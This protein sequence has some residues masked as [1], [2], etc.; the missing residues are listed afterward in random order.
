MKTTRILFALSLLSLL[1]LSSCTFT[2][3][4]PEGE[5]P[6]E[7]EEEYEVIET[8]DIRMPGEFEPSSSVI[9]CYPNNM[10][11]SVYKTIAKDNKVLLLVNSSHGS[12]K[13]QAQ[14]D[15]A[16]AGINTDNVTF[17][18]MNLDDDY[19]YWAR[20]FS[21][22]F[23]FNATKLSI[24][25]FTYNRP[26]RVNQNKV[27]QR[28]S[29]TLNM[30]YEFMNI[31]H[32]G[33][34]LMQDG[35]GTAFSDDLVVD[36]NDDN[37]DRVI[38]QMKRYTGTDNYVITIDP[39]GDYIAHIDCW[40]KIV[41]PDKIIVARL[42]QSN[43]RYSCYE[44]V[45]EQLAN[46]KCA[47]GYNYRIYRVEEP[48]GNTIAPYTNSLIL[49]KNVYVP[50]GQNA[51]YNSNAIEV[52]K[53][54]LPGYNIVGV[55]G[56]DFDSYFCFLNTDALHCRTHE[57]PDDDMLFIDSREVYNGE[58]EYK[59]SYLVKTNIV[60]YADEEIDYVKIHYSINGEAYQVADMV[61]YEATSNYT[62]SFTN[63]NHGDDVKYYI[64]A[65]DVGNNYNVDPTCGNKD[66]HHFQVA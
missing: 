9:M 66:P 62:Y 46:E 17:L 48:G 35:R 43:P 4:T 20:D 26:Q 28:L 58:V 15:F 42:P 8:F 29:N 5:V 50:M 23:T 27:P 32:T 65:S 10:P 3:V 21:P 31:V 47:Y 11:L 64:D 22:F 25:D 1:A 56:Y 55:D 24:T 13:T 41:A 49:N 12:Q 45:A 53:E 44:Q 2:R 39:Q 63:L 61:K 16:N 6:G 7:D 52:Y 18:D 33:G 51:T 60:S 38:S 57:I 54:A 36:E 59:D 19:S 30:D 34:N 14:N 40:A 37:R